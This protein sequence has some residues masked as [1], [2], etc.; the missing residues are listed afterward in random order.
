MKYPNPTFIKQASG[1]KHGRRTR[2]IAAIAVITVVAAACWF[3]NR[4]A[5]MEKLYEEE[6]PDL[7]G[8][9]ADETDAA[10]ESVPEPFFEETVPAGETEA[11]EETSEETE[12]SD[13]NFYFSNSYP[14]QT[15]SHETRDQY[16]D[17]LKQ[18]IQDYITEHSTER[19]CVRYSNLRT[20]ENLGINDLEPI[21]PA[22]SMSLP[23]ALCIADRLAAGTLSPDKSYTYEGEAPEGGS[24][25][26]YDTAS[27]GTSYTVTDLLPLAISQN[28]SLALNYLLSPMGGMDGFAEEAS[29]ISGYIRFDDSVLYENYLGEA[30]QGTGRT[31]VYDMNTFAEYLYSGYINH[32]ENYQTII[33]AMRDCTASNGAKNI[34]GTSGSV[35]AVT[36][37]NEE[38]H[39]Y[40]LTAIVD[41]SEPFAL[42]IYCEC[43]SYER[44][45]EI[46]SNISLFVSN[47]ISSCHN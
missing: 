28:D 25:V 43:E 40:T 22:G 19:I 21:C 3:I 4:M 1:I 31:S 6:Y 30:Y 47:F 24:S 26:I 10:D 27:A 9:S 44:A 16:L 17:D 15:I 7:V 11:S 2:I 8:I 34:F 32:P 37:R 5:N 35:L 39:A 42:T 18:E 38:L 33:N 29:A 12:V 36:G 46:Q 41:C 13:D 20:N 45:V 14:L 23:V